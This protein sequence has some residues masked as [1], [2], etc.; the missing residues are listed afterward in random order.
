MRNDFLFF[1][2]FGGHK[3]VT[4]ERLNKWVSIRTDRSLKNITTLDGYLP[5]E[6]WAT[7]CMGLQFATL[8]PNNL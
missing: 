8:W 3:L 2:F 6:A 5:V 7:K 4:V 1:L